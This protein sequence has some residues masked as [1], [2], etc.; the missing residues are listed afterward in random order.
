MANLFKRVFF[1]TLLTTP[2]YAYLD[3]GTG[4]MLLYFILGIVATL[5]YSI[6]SFFYK[7]KLF[8][9]S[10][11]SKNITTSSDLDIVIY[12]EGGKY[13]S[14]F[15]PLLQELSN[16]ENLKIGYYTYDNSDKALDF[17]ANNLITKSFGSELKATIAMN[18]LEA[19][20][21]VM[22]TPQLN[23]MRLLRSPKVK[24]Y[25]HLIH[26]PTDALLYRKF[27]FDYFDSV[28]CSGSHQI[29]SIRVLEKSRGL[30]QKLLLE[31]GL[32][33]YDSMLEEK[34][35]FSNINRDKKTILIAPTWGSISMFTKFG[36]AIFE[37]FLD[38]KYN[39]IF[40]PHPQLYI[41]QKKL[42]DEI[43]RRL[44]PYSDFV[45]IDR[46]SSGAKSMH[47]SDIMI[48]DVSGIIFDYFF[49]Y[50]KPILLVGSRVDI[51]GLEGEFVSRDVWEVTV[52]DKIATI[53]D[54]KDLSRLSLIVDKS[55]NNSKNIDY[56]KFISESIFNFGK[57][58]KV[59]AKQLIDILED[60]KDDN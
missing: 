7:I 51:G 10:G 37:P 55:L 16:Y 60:L 22:T 6:K 41:S 3:P 58:S 5:F 59:C 38:G 43:E 24:H 54:D 30:A 36:F 53:I 57:S 33:Y 45:S 15:K 56:E 1:L 29:E 12:S 20:L 14:L 18:N 9:L 35:S 42:I 23:I 52:F 21:V 49:I 25:S 44:A 28:L 19:K 11:G 40:R 32:L 50:Q 39:I 4:S 17:Q 8:I 13:W 48:S 27:A 31:T 2:L 26:A 46:A 34:N 47:I